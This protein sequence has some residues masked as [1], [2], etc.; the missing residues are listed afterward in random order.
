VCLFGATR[1]SS[2]AHGL[3][4]AMTAVWEPRCFPQGRLG[5]AGLSGGFAPAGPLRSRPPLG[6]LARLAAR[7]ES[8]QRHLPGRRARARPRGSDSRAASRARGPASPC[9]RQ[10][11]RRRL[12]GRAGRGLG[13]AWVLRPPPSSSQ[14]PPPGAQSAPE[15]LGSGRGRYR[16]LALRWLAGL[17]EGS[18]GRSS[19]AARAGLQGD[20]G[21]RTA[22]ATTGLL[23]QDCSPVLQGPGCPGAAADWDGKI[24]ARERL[25]SA[26]ARRGSPERVRGA[27][28]RLWGN[29]TRAHAVRASRGVNPAA[30]AH[31]GYTAG[32]LCGAKGTEFQGQ[33]L[34][35]GWAGPLIP[36]SELR[37]ARWFPAPKP[38]RF[39]KVVPRPFCFDGAFD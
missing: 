20:R 27:R 32:N 22:A 35:G 34:P 36:H 1:V 5:S 16:R 18:G 8:R 29:A 17:G 9:A 10:G 2:S 7:P 19:V 25:V 31:A 28:P 4:S 39:R 14:A 23:L 33:R 21:A 37:P 26:G 3:Q 30:R 12:R 13:G 38:Q 24:A 11:R 15:R 6:D